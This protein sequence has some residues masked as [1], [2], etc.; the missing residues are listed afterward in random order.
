MPVNREFGDWL[1]VNLTADSI[2]NYLRRRLESF[3]YCGE[4]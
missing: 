2:E 1:L 4:C 3:E